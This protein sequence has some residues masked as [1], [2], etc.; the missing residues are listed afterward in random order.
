[1][2]H[3]N[4][5]NHVQNGIVLKT[6]NYAACCTF[7]G[8]KLGLP[9]IFVEDHETWN[10]TCFGIGSGYLMVETGGIG[11]P[12]E[13][14]FAQSPVKIRLNVD[15]LEKSV[16]EIRENGLDAEIQRHDWGNVS[17]INDPDGNRIAL[18]QHS[19]VYTLKS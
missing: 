5:G 14:S 3:R 10:I 12:P 1:M 16:A 17:E 9:V 11:A 15:D 2:G 8:E 4:K 18:R 6:E 19:S 7:Y 13:K